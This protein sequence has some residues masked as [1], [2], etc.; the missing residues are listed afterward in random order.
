M[1]VSLVL[2]GSLGTRLRSSVRKFKK[3]PKKFLRH[4]WTLYQKNLLPKLPTIWYTYLS[5][6]VL[7]HL[8]GSLTR[9]HSAGD[10]R[11]PKVSIR[12][13]CIQRGRSRATHH[14]STY[15][16]MYHHNTILELQSDS[17]GVLD[18]VDVF[19]ITSNDKSNQWLRH[20]NLY[21]EIELWNLYK[22]IQ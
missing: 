12:N 20:M 2:R 5:Y 19:S 6:N 13:V 7:H 9:F 22:Y 1:P 14:T 10:S 4:F 3:S 15:M 8:L 18:I 11:N 21:K 16:Y 17:T